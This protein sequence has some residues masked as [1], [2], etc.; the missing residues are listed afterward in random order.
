MTDIV[1]KMKKVNI[2]FIFLIDTSGMR[3]LIYP[4]YITKDA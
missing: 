2:N 4:C 3:V 1:N